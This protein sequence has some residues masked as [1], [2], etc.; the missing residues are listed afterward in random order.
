MRWREHAGEYQNSLIKRQFLEP[1]LWFSRDIFRFKRFALL[2]P[3]ALFKAQ[4]L[5]KSS[6]PSIV[7]TRFRDVT[8]RSP[9]PSIYRNLEYFSPNEKH[10]PHHALHHTHYCRHPIALFKYQF[11]MCEQVYERNRR[12]KSQGQTSSTMTFYSVH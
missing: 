7:V 3:K 4:V 1:P 8:G 10:F 11:R 12:L 6:P 5:Q 2:C 9:Y